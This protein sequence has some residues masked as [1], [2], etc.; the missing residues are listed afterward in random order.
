M[1][2]YK[3]RAIKKKKINNKKRKNKKINK[4]IFSRLVNFSLRSKFI[5]K[6]K[7]LAWTAIIITAVNFLLAIAFIVYLYFWVKVR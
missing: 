2:K 3:L 1:N 6:Q 5:N 4:L 7:F